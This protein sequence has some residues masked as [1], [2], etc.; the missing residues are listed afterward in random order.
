[1]EIFLIQAA[2]FLVYEMIL[3]GTLILY[4]FYKADWSK[5][6]FMKNWINAE[7]IKTPLWKGISVILLVPLII[8]GILY[9]G[10]ANAEPKYLDGAVVFVGIDNTT[11]ASP[12]CKNIGINDRLTSN[13]GF[14]QNIMTDKMFNVG[15]KYTHHSCALNPDDKAYD[16]I[17]IVLEWKIW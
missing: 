10:N 11:S 2:T 16:S 9:A 15:A 6:Q 1:M 17:G 7:G 12:F 5:E 13:I 3:L 8:S 14:V 4:A